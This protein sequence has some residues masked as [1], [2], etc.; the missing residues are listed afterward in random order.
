MAK[1]SRETSRIRRHER[2][3]TKVR[4]SQARPRLAVYRSLSHIYA[5]LIDDEAG[6][7]VA[8]ASSLETKA[9][10]KKKSESA[11][12]V[13]QALGERAKQAGVAEAVFDRG[14]YQYHGRVKALADGVRA[15]GV[16]V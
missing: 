4:G 1:E 11:K 15:A 8:S 14:G 2:V 12:A 10:K 9:D 6:K 7:T 16:K 5:Q 13:G 3:R